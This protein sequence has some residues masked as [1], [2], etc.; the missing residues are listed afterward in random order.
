LD[1]I[2]ALEVLSEGL[3][4]S[5]ELIDK[6]DEIFSKDKKKEG[7][8]LS[9]IHKAKGLEAD[10]IFIVIIAV[11]A[12]IIPKYQC[13]SSFLKAKAYLRMII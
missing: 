6:I 7:I 11:A 10:N 1:I 3:K 9:T 4:T 2:K 5:K 12:A 8:S 13:T